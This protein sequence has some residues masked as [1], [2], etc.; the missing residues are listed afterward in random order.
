MSDPID[1]EN[2]AGSDVAVDSEGT[3]DAEYE[4]RM[5]MNLSIL[6]ICVHFFFSF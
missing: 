2:H 3:Q 4:L 5:A 6:F 1:A